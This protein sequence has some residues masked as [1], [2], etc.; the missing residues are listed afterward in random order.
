MKKSDKDEIIKYIHEL[1][2]SDKYNNF[3]CNFR[4]HEDST[5]QLLK[6]I[7][8][9][10]IIKQEMHQRYFPKNL[11]IL[12]KREMAYY[13]NKDYSIYKLL[14][15]G[16][17]LLNI[18][19][20][21]ICKYIEL[22]RNYENALFAENYDLALEIL[23]TIEKT[24]CCSIWTTYQKF[25]VFN[26]MK[27]QFE[28]QKQLDKMQ[29]DSH[30]INF[31][32][33]LML[34]Y[35]KMTDSSIN[36]DEYN[37][38]LEQFLES[39]D[40][41]NVAWRYFNFKLNVNETKDIQGLK[42]ALIFDE[43]NSIIDY[44]E[45][46]IDALQIL[47][48]KDRYTDFIG[49]CVKLLC[50]QNK[51]YR[52][53]NL[54]TAIV[55]IDDKVKLDNKAC[56]IIEN[57]TCGMYDKV[58]RDIIEYFNS[59]SYDFVFCNLYMKMDLETNE[60]KIP[61]LKFWT[62]I[63]KIYLFQYD[64]KSSIQI[65]GGYYKLFSGTSWKYKILS[66]MVRKLNYKMAS[67]IL[68]CSILND[69]IY[70]PLYYQCILSKENQIEYLMKFQEISPIT[71]KLQNFVL[72]GNIEND[73]L[74]KIDPIRWKY[75]EIKQ[76]TKCGECSIAIHKCCQLLDYF[77]NNKNMRYY[78][79]RIRRT[80]YDCYLKVNEF[81]KAM[82]L[83]IDSYLIIQELVV[84]MDLGLLIQALTYEDDDLIKGNISRP[85]L[86]SL[87]YEM[88][89]EEIIS[90]D[91][92]IVSAYLDY[93]EFKGCTTIIQL[94][95]SYNHL[96]EIDILFLNRVC[97]QT[98]LMKD[99]VSKTEAGGSA[100]ELRAEVL[101]LLIKKDRRSE[102]VKDYLNELNSIYKMTQLQKKINSFNH[103]RIFIDT[104]NLYLYMKKELERE[105]SKYKTVQDL[106]NT[107]YDGK[108]FKQKPDLA[109]VLEQYIDQ[110]RFFTNIV[111]KIK[112]AY[113]NESPYSLECFL[114]TRIRH[115]F[116]ND[117]LKKVFEEEKLFSKKMKDNSV[118]YIVNDYWKNKLP[119]E[120]Y[121]LVIEE[122]SKFSQT[123]DAKIQEIKD[124]WMRIKQD[125]H[126]EGMFDYR[127]FTEFFL[128]YELIYIQSISSADDFFNTVIGSLDFKTSSIL[129]AIRNKIENDLKVYYSD[130]ISRLEK[131]VK[132]IEFNRLVKNEMLRNIE[133]SKAKYIDDIEIFK[134][135]FNM[136]HE[137]Y[138]DFSMEE[139]I[140]FCLEIEKDMNNQ[141]RKAKIKSSIHNNEIFKGNIFPYLVD[142]IGI[143]IRNAV[144][145][146]HITEM[147]KLSIG[148]DIC[149]FSGSE[150]EKKI[151]SKN[152]HCQFDYPIIFKVTN[153][154]NEDE[155]LESIRLKISGKIND[156]Y[157]GVFRDQSSQEGGSGLYKTARIIQY[158]LH[159]PA[160][161]YSNVENN[162][163]EINIAMDLE[164][165]LRK[166]IVD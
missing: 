59:H 37:I 22:K 104:E 143:L 90:A 113:L 79:E 94:L 35:A 81:E 92:E 33:L 122:L 74:I 9:I 78:E 1:K 28:I 25:L 129:N 40:K 39:G 6:M 97:N 119:E 142:I 111:E 125:S 70:T 109:F 99:Y 93:L 66:I 77:Y 63:N 2:E 19:N 133:I 71:T 112:R 7:S 10:R 155:D 72:S 3:F 130:S 23:N 161:Y 150:I 141:F 65:I 18:F 61:H 16:T 116:C 102:R 137:Q 30:Q 4:L 69:Y 45:T 106:R 57:Y 144:E 56:E 14:L 100:A 13:N 11:E 34:Y 166:D 29:E 36:F 165:Y 83:Y 73:A 117:N 145:H 131:Q 128:N 136:E 49:E 147:D 60:F 107:L 58:K 158:G 24:L 134:D 156:I 96:N 126:S 146:S 48:F 42:S 101:K 64:I 53:R 153:N 95:N 82:N 105:F 68:H 123:I 139:L 31:F 164:N 98:I 120:E 163:C 140:E 8:N 127:G 124:K 138:P 84:H 114:S 157:T 20:E 15:W 149:S 132:K 152:P 162:L 159:S 88:K 87:F 89:D 47:C 85:I 154:L 75:Y 38:V 32:Y 91:D 151:M 148:I 55:K 46:Y 115:N 76:L 118:D 27:K 43:Q 110:Q 160:A 103:N 12:C 135:I 62:E 80:L 67:S 26:F 51:D 5:D 121:N 108:S 50:P 86:Y 44:Y 52:I 54:Y 17:E 21:D 41:Q